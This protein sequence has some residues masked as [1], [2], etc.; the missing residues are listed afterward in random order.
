MVNFPDTSLMEFLVGTVF[1]I[2]GC[3]NLD[4]A[5]LNFAFASLAGCR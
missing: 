2:G 1:P 4:A 5:N 3:P